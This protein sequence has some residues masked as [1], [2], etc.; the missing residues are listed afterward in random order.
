MKTENNDIRKI[1]ELEDGSSIYEI[2][3]EVQEDVDGSFH[4]NLA[5]N[6]LKEDALKKLSSFLIDS[7]EQDIE[8]RKPW[9]DVIERVKPYLG[10]SLEDLVDIPF[11]MATRTFDTTLATALTRFYAITRAELLPQAGPAGF[12]INGTSDSHLEQEG[13]RIRDNLNNY[14]TRVDKSYYTDYERFLIYLGFYGS[15]VRKVYFD[16]LSNRP[17]SRFIIPE[18]FIIDSDCTSILESNRIT[19]VLHLSKREILLNQQNGIYRDVELPYL[20]SLADTDQD[21]LTKNINK[22]KEEVNLEAYTKRSLFSIYEVHS[23]LNLDDFTNESNDKNDEVPLPYIITI[24]E[25]T[26]EILSIRRNW[27]EGDSEKKRINYF[28]HYIRS[29][30]FGIYGIGL[31][32]SIG[33]NAINLTTLQRLLM[34][35]GKF[36]NLPGGLRQKGF[37]QQENDL[38]VGPGQFLEVNTG[39]IPLQEAFMPLPYSGPDQTLLELYNRQIDQTKELASTSEMGMLDSK[40]DIPV[41]TAIA[42]LETNNRISSAIMRSIH[43]SF[44]IELQLID[45]FLRESSDFAEDIEIIP[46]SDPATNSTVQRIM[47]A[48]ATMQLAMEAPDLHNMREVFK[49]NYQAQGLNEKDI[50]KILKPAPEEE[51]VLPVDPISAYMNILLGKPVKAAIWQNHPAY[52]LDLSIFAQRPEI[53]NKPEAMGA[54]QALVTEHQA[55]QFLIEMQKL[56]GFELPSLEQ[57][58]DPQIQNAIALGIAQK[59]E[60]SGATKPQQEQAPIDPNALL[61]A[62]IQQKEAETAAKERIANLKAETDVFRAQLDF[63]KEK[64]KIESQEDIAQLKSETELIKQGVSNEN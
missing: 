37:K 43:S 56:L 41:G 44:S 29:P 38:L 55:F 16:K 28:V 1:E 58:Q 62:D 36:K 30:G 32:H 14:L 59:L 42:F 4:D 57:L 19:H 10:F 20:K 26:K 7:I 6:H 11:K 25:Y 2:G 27:E 22:N 64:A 54:L 31:A 40:E 24:D 39:G 45:K 5:V 33:A 52:I 9:L 34:D 53:Q 23:Y 3:P 35:A 61:M 8:A 17:L 60:E 13:E 46:V 12:K 50:S 18:D 47:K 51:E 63:E 48:Q 15:C 21:S 49:L